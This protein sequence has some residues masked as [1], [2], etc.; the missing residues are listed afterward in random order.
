[1]SQ[2]IN[3]ILIKLYIFELQ[4]GGKPVLFIDNYENMYQD[5]E[6]K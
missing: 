3:E 5:K 1:M 2:C 6:H 4:D